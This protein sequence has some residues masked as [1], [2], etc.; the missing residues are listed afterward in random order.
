MEKGKWEEIWKRENEHNLT[1]DPVKYLSFLD[2]YR[3]NSKI[4]D[5]G[6]GVMYYLEFL[7]DFSSYIIGIDISKIALETAKEK[8]KQKKMDKHTNLIQASCFFLPLRNSCFD[9]VLCMSLFS[10]L[11]ENY[12][13]AFKESYR[14]TKGCIGFNITHKMILHKK[15]GAVLKKYNHGWLTSSKEGIKIFVSDENNISSLLKEFELKG[16]IDVS[17][18]LEFYD[19]KEEMIIKCMKNKK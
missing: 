15:E 2:C 1:T 14:V 5:V 6:C 17:P 19:S 8:I 18:S 4:L 11:G 13:E 3:K 7:S 16:E 12:L 9:L 10:L